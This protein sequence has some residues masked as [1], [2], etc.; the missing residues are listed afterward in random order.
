MRCFYL[1]Q[2]LVRAYEPVA[3]QSMTLRAM[4]TVPMSKFD[5]KG[6]DFDKLEKNIAIVKKRYVVGPWGSYSLHW[7]WC[8]YLF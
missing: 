8:I 6:I 2:S 4:S 1:L 3:K 7:M 5:T